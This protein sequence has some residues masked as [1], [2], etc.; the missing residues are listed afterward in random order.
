MT[1][2]R[3]YY[4]TDDHIDFIHMLVKDKARNSGEDWINELANIIEDQIVNHPSL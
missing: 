3:D 1:E 4:F 2:L